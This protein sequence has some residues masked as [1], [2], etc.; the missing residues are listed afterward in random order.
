MYVEALNN[1]SMKEIKG[2]DERLSGLQQLLEMVQELKQSQAEMAKVMLQL[3]GT[4]HTTA[5]L[6]LLVRRQSTIQE[7]LK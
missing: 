6:S 1:A 4:T 7:V 3:E 5:W 2:L